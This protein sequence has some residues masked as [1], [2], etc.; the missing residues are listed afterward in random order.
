[1]SEVAGAVR[2]VQAVIADTVDAYHL[3]AEDDRGSTLHV[4]VVYQIAG[5]P[6]FRPFRAAKASPVELQ[7]E[8]DRLIASSR[9]LGVDV[10]IER[11]ESLRKIM[12]QHGLGIDCSRF[13]YEV[14]SR[15]YHRLQLPDYASEVFRDGEM[16]RDLHAAG[17]WPARD[18]SGTDRNL[19]AE[20]AR[21]LHDVRRVPVSWIRDVLG[22]DPEFITGA[23]H[24]CDE[25]AT[26]AVQPE[27]LL[28]G[29]LLA[30]DAASGKGVSHLAVVDEAVAGARGIEISFWHSWHTRDHTAGLRRDRLLVTE[31]DSFEWSHPGL[32]NPKRYRGYAF[33]R[34]AALAVHYAQEAASGSSNQP[35]VV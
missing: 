4:P 12:S 8:L 19:T 15:V 10:G 6:L 27:A 30:F 29:D 13:G 26:V 31:G 17:R 16:V 23:A 7:T 18:L 21:T 25:A 33:R 20:E 1:M 34:P 2:E 22:K 32:E 28:A 14:L 3:T 24:M 11:I 5:E 9:D 35:V